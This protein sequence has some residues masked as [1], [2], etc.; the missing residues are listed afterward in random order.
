MESTWRGGFVRSLTF[1]AYDCNR[2]HI[3]RIC[4]IGMK[5]ADQPTSA[6]G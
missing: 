5:P 6:F 2:W 3:M 1:L 4:R